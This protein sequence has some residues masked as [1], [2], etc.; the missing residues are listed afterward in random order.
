VRNSSHW[1]VRDLGAK[2]LRDYLNLGGTWSVATDYIYR[3]GLLLAAETQTGQRHFHLDHLGTPRLITRAG[4]EKVA[5]HVY[6]PFGEEATVYNQDTE[7]M[8]FTGHER[9]LANPSIPGDDLDYMH[10]RHESPVT[11]RF[12]SVD[13]AITSARQASPQ[14]W[15]RY[16]YVIDNPVHWIDPSG[17]APIEPVM[18]QFLE[19]F[20]GTNLS[21][22]DVEWGMG[23]SM[24]TDAAGGA[25]AVTLGSTIYLARREEE[26]YLGGSERSTAMMAHEIVHSFDYARLGTLGFLTS[27]AL[28]GNAGL[29]KTDS[30]N[31]AYTNISF[32]VRANEVE[33]L[34]T[35]FLNNNT[36]I[37]DKMSQGT[38]LTRED[39]Q[40]V[41]DYALSQVSN[42]TLREG[43]QYINGQLVYVR[44]TVK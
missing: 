6:Y 38:L 33:G 41:Q 42:G 11:G 2:V 3:D 10:A 5:Y 35:D 43:F 18:K 13:P 34:V 19:S 25:N 9:D 16:S 4:G 30:L 7:R 26:K 17:G 27:Y 14:T 1:T 20:F 32:E 23:P 22:I 29:T 37:R 15:N 28:E 12:L 40:R 31:T 24:I 44:L 21:Y 39:Q 8:K 36:D